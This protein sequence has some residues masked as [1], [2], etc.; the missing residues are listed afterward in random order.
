M[1]K[2]WDLCLPEMRFRISASLPE[3]DRADRSNKLNYTCPPHN[4]AS[5]PNDYSLSLA[6]TAIPLGTL[7]H[8]GLEELLDL[9]VDLVRLGAAEGLD[10]AGLHGLV[11][12]QERQGGLFV[13]LETRL[14][15]FWLVVLAL[16]EWLTGDVVEACQNRSMSDRWRERELSHVPGFFGG[17]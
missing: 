2:E 14:H 4:R 5:P 1:K 8:V 3:R 12:V 17:L 9:W 15:H 6:A 13:Q 10:L 11:V 16:G 7:L